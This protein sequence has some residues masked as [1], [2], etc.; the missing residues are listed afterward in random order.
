M[1]AL[2]FSPRGRI[3]RRE[4][5]AG[6]VFAGVLSTVLILASSPGED[7]ADTLRA[8]AGLSPEVLGS[9]LAGGQ[10]DAAALVTALVQSLPLPLVLVT[11]V[12]WYCQICLTTKRLHDR[13]MS[14]WWQ[15]VGLVPV[16]GAL[17]L[18]VVCGMRD[19]DP[20]T[21][22]FGPPSRARAAAEGWSDEQRLDASSIDAI[23][24]RHA[25]GG[26]APVASPAVPSPAPRSARPSGGFGRRQAP[27]R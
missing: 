14:G 20:D 12:S 26:P 15:L 3:G 17:W 6:G 16:A 21:N 2:L 1:I 10:V 8:S 27:P 5:W 23:I 4:W 24:A 25:A 19:G 18:V 13:G 9:S 11:L 7:A 22:R